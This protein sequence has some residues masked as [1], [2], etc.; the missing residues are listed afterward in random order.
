ML[1][2]RRLRA[3]WPNGLWDVGQLSWSDRLALNRGVRVGLVRQH[4]RVFSWWGFEVRPRYTWAGTW[5]A[6]ND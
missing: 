6:D 2:L 4:M 1:R 3:R 5:E